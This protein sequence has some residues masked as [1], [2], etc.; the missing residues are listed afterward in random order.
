MS[1]EIDKREGYI[2][3]RKLIQADG[4]A[5]MHMSRLGRAGLSYRDL[6]RDISMELPAAPVA[7][8]DDVP[9]AKPVPVGTPRIVMVLVKST[10]ESNNNNNTKEE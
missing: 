1:S 10:F 6:P 7:T 2:R 5:Q 9:M 8:L 3:N 4:S